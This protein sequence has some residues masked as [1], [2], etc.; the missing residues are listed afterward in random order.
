MAGHWRQRGNR[1]ELRA[2]TGCGLLVGKMGYATRSIA[3]VGKREVRQGLIGVGGRVDRGRQWEDSH[4]RCRHDVRR[5]ARAMARG[6]STA[7]GRLCAVA[8]ATL[9]SAYEGLWTLSDSE[10]DR[11]YELMSRVSPRS[12]VL[13]VRA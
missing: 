2:Y 7:M 13:L 1:I 3:L 8:E 4:R 9:C 5:P 6:P 12:N 11:R 10:R